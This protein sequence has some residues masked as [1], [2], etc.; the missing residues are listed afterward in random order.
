M[1]NYRY[2]MF[3]MYMMGLCTLPLIAFVF[4]C[5]RPLP[6]MAQQEKITDAVV[7]ATMAAGVGPDGKMAQ[8]RVDGDGHVI[9]SAHLP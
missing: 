4:M 1:E 7:E 3:C 6:T 5:F 9:C 2:K 8:I